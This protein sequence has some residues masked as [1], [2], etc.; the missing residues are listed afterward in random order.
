MYVTSIGLV[1]AEWWS[2]SQFSHH[3]IASIFDHLLSNFYLEFLIEGQIIPLLHKAWLPWWWM[4]QTVWILTCLETTLILSWIIE[5]VGLVGSLSLATSCH[6]KP[7]P[8]L[9]TVWKARMHSIL[10]LPAPRVTASFSPSIESHQNLKTSKPN[11][12]YAPFLLVSGKLCHK[13]FE[14]ETG[15]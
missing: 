5:L 12:L 1:I 15:L 11:M 9:C 14:T 8:F 4:V 13:P 10:S 2:I 7:S 6:D 3:G